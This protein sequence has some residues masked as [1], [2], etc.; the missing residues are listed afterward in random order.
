MDQLHDE[1]V[2]MM[3]LCKICHVYAF[4]SA[5]RMCVIECRTVKI[6]NH[7]NN[8]YLFYSSY[9]LKLTEHREDMSKDRFWIVIFI[10]TI[11]VTD[12]FIQ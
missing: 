1:T 8:T 5:Y 10:K 6:S 4:G 12:P 9:N 2:A 7:L 3:G 11:Q